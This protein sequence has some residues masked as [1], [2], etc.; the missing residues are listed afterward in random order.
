MNIIIM[1]PEVG[2]INYI[3][4]THTRLAVAKVRMDL[5]LV[6]RCVMSDLKCCPQ[7]HVDCLRPEKEFGKEP[8]M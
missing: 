3:P 8:G 5:A 2:D 4:I 6:R 7:S 1:S